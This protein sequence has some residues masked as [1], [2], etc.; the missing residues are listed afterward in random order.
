GVTANKA[1]TLKLVQSI[2]EAK[3]ERILEDDR[4]KRTF[5]RQ[6]A[7]LEPK[8]DEARSATGDA[9][10]AE[11]GKRSVED[12]VTE[13]LDIV[14]CDQRGEPGA[15]GVFTTGGWLPGMTIRQIDPAAGG[16]IAG[17]AGGTLSGIYLGIPT[18]D[19]ER[20][21]DRVLEALMKDGT[22]IRFIRHSNGA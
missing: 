21:M 7:E 20:E 13:I 9:D 12:M 2:N 10:E 17:I 5:E 19:D 15:W 18:A 16:G 14:R 22:V 4:L 6:F 3:T 11:G 8:L 1:G